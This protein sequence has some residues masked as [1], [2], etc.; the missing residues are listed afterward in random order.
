VRAVPPRD[1][2]RER[3]QHRGTE[4]PVD[5]DY[6]HGGYRVHEAMVTGWQVTPH[7][8]DPVTGNGKRNHRVTVTTAH[9]AGSEP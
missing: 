1:Q 6:V 3:G 9:L 7:H 8:Q 5:P 2:A 4:M